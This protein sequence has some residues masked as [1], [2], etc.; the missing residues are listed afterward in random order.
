MT[1][2]NPIISQKVTKWQLR[3]I[4]NEPEY[5]SQMRRR[6][7]ER[8]M[9]REDLAPP[10][11]QQVPGALSR[12]YDIWDNVANQFLGTFHCYRNPDGTIG[13]SGME[14]PMWLW[15]DGTYFYDP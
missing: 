9:V 12:V 6:T 13:A 1:P 7:T 14:D 5:Q 4:W 2:P 11:A 15:A 10:D 3:A 8:V